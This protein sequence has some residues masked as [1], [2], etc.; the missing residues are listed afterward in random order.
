MQQTEGRSA[1]HLNGLLGV[2]AS[3]DSIGERPENF[4]QQRA[5]LNAKVRMMKILCY[6]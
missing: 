3:V 2:Q 5:E 6:R 4:L 1:T